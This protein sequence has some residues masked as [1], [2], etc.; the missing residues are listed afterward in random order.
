M[1]SSKEKRSV[2][3]FGWRP[4]VPARSRDGSDE[5]GRDVGA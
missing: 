3:L 1:S 2:P 5:L 4:D